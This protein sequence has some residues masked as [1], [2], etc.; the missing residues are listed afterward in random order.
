MTAGQ[1]AG[2]LTWVVV[3]GED[4][5]DL[6]AS[7]PVSERAVVRA[8]L[9][10]VMGAVALIF[11]PLLAVF[12]LM[13]P[14]QALVAAA[15]VA[16]STASATS[17]QLWFR[18]QARRSTFRRRQQSSRIATFA[19]AFSSISWAFAGAMAAAQ[20]WSATLVLGVMALAVLAAVRWISPA[21][22][23]AR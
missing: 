12:A 19:E 6:I 13:A 14:L 20:S 3:S 1:L 4:A 18:A 22:A 15:G 17:V 23:S 11:T 21:R 8:K 7:A 5:P 2:G 10:A 16:I 9:E